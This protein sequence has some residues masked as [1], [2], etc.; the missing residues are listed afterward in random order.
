[1]STD[2]ARAQRD[3]AVRGRSS[4]S[5]SRGGGG[6]R[7]R[8][9]RRVRPGRCRGWPPRQHRRSN[10]AATTSPPTSHRTAPSTSS[11]P[12]W[13]LVHVADRERALRVMT[14][15]LRPGGWLL[16]EDADPALQPLI[17]PD[18][19]GRRAA[20]GQQAPP[21]LPRAPRRAR[22]GAVVRPPPPTPVARGGPDRRPGGRLL[23]CHRPGLW[24]TGDSHRA[25]GARPVGGQGPRD[26]GGDRHPPHQHRGGR[27]GPGD[28]P[29]DLGLGT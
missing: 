8:P 24:G 13:S 4:G 2:R 12:D 5:G 28:V 17:C 22:R 1:M 11:T 7:R 6:R 18:E 10:S 9:P 19:S 29:D 20:A 14:D 21:R 3:R 25:T 15:A 27:P 26:A 16:L 23:P